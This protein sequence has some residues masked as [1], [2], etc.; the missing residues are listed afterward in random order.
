MFSLNYLKPVKISN[1]NSNLFSEFEEFER[2]FKSD[3]RDKKIDFIIENKEYTEEKIQ[4]L[5]EY[6]E[7][8]SK[9]VKPMSKPSSLLFFYHH[10]YDTTKL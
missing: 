4:D 3:Q 7:I 10:K 5:K 2:K 8:F 9:S 6:K 1:S